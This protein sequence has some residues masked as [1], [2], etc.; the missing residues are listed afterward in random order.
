MKALVKTGVVFTA[1]MI[2]I[3]AAAQVNDCNSV[4]Q[5]GTFKYSQFSSNSFFQQIIYS[6]F[7]ESTY[8][9]SKSD[10]GIGIDI[11]I[12]EAVI[13]H[14]NYSEAEYN[15]KKASIQD[16]HFSKITSVNYTSSM[17]SSGDGDI[18]KAWNACI[19]QNAGGLTVR[20]IP[21]TATKVLVDLR[22]LPQGTRYRT[23][24]ASDVK[25]DGVNS[26]ADVS[27]PAC[28]R[29][30]TWITQGRGCQSSV[31]LKD[32]WTPLVITVNATD[33]SAYAFAPARI[34]LKNERAP[35][36]VPNYTVEL[37]RQGE[38]TEAER[39]YQLPGDLRLAG[40]VID[41]ASVRGAVAKTFDNG[42]SGT[43]YCAGPKT[44]PQLYTIAY[45]F[46][47]RSQKSGGDGWTIGCRMTVQGE[48][49]RGRWVTDETERLP[50]P[51]SEL[52]SDKPAP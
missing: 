36:S 32:A 46:N 17:I 21:L 35:L 38:R 31:T 52:G 47:S 22:W 43:N 14:G 6:R 3:P 48:M 5:N 40:W 51:P 44:R 4:L 16:E 49:M 39:S 19:A 45:T 37:K 41:P 29:R 26:L 9:S 30:K 18:L 42:R 8:A 23:R 13:G 50:P 20:I 10:R 27:E 24:L 15:A 33:G 11:P 28:F 7:I 34:T 12:G 1:A 25:L 2:A